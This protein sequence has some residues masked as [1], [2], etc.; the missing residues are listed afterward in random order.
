VISFRMAPA[1]ISEMAGTRPA[2]PKLE[3]AVRR[4]G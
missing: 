4:T 3:N 1:P 2:M